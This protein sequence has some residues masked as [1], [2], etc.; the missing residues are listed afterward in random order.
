MAKKES[1]RKRK[2]DRQKLKRSFG[3]AW[4][5]VAQTWHTEQ[6][7]RVEVGVGSFALLFGLLLGVDLVP[8]ILCCSL[9]L[10]LEVMNSA[11]EATVDL[12]SPG[13]HPLAKRAK[14]AAAGAVLLAAVGSVFV[15]LVVLGP[16]LWAFVF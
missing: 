10:S 2:L 11:L 16:P 8:I 3:F 5:G 7:F 12:L 4:I 13:D 14:D 1:A 15:G 9:V 6:N